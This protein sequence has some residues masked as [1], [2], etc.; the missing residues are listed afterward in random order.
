MGQ[1][2]T[3]PSPPGDASALVFFDSYTFGSIGLAWLAFAHAFPIQAIAGGVDRTACDGRSCLR[4][5]GQE[6]PRLQVLH[7][8]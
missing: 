3:P 7:L 5:P 6:H 4:L 8:F 1:A 2:I